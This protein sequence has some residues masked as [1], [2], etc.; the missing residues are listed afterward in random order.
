MSLLQTEESIAQV[1]KQ[2]GFRTLSYFSREFAKEL[3]ITP[4]NYRNQSN[5]K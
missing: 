2:S 4:S 1:A 5:Q 3:G